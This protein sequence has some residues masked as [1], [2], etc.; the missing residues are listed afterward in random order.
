MTPRQ[1]RNYID[2]MK[3]KFL[4]LKHEIE[5]TEADLEHTQCQECIWRLLDDLDFM[6]EVIEESQDFSE[7]LSSLEEH[8]AEDEHLNGWK[9][10]DRVIEF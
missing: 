8:L 1:L 5:I 10:D 3:S 2:E 6:Y 4:M 7:N 9:G